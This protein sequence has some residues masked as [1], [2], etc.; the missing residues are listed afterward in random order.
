MR[1]VTF[2]IKATMEE[3]WVNHFLNFL[4]RM[5]LDGAVGHSELIGFYADGD[6]DFQPKFDFSDNVEMKEM[7][8]VP[9]KAVSNHILVYD[10]G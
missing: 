1:E 3:R 5:E 6:G 7:Y 4:K 8:R 2:T 9:F 10:A